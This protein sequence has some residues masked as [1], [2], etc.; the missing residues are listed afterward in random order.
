VFP[1][2]IVGMP[3]TAL[4]SA[5]AS[6][7]PPLATALREGTFALHREAERAGIMRELLRGRVTRGGYCAL[8]RNLHAL[9]WTLEANLTRHAADQAIAVIP[10]PVLARSAALANDL[11]SLHGARW[12][13]ELPLATA[14]VRYV[15]RLDE[16]A[17]ADPRALL[18]HA[19]VRYL[20][21]LSGGQI[22]RRVIASALALSEDSGQAFYRFPEAPQVLAA[23]LRSALDSITLTPEGQARL[24][25]EARLAFRYHIELFEQLGDAATRPV[26]AP[27]S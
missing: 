27:P 1:E 21:D 16:V 24:V 19:Y 18:S 14:M 12:E 13:R 7:R 8:L 4:L 23:R 9:Y 11:E 17:R 15:E 22:V 6:P 26:I 5:D 2:T 20:G 25:D 3:L 10:L